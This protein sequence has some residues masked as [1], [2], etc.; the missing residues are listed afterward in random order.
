MFCDVFGHM[1]M[2][3]VSER[4]LYPSITYKEKN[5][6]CV[7]TQGTELKVIAARPEVVL[8]RAV[9]ESER[10]PSRRLHG[11]IMQKTRF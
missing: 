7:L 1:L 11:P 9:S 4:F 5:D 8:P 3:V 10:C 6:F 2:S